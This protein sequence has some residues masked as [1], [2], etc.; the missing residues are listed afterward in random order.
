MTVF[1]NFEFLFQNNGTIFQKKFWLKSFLM[2]S[3]LA[4]LM[5]SWIWESYKYSTIQYC[6]HTCGLYNMMAWYISSFRQRK[7]LLSGNS[8]IVCGWLKN[9]VNTILEFQTAW[10]F[11]LVFLTAS[12]AQGPRSHFVGVGL[13]TFLIFLYIFFALL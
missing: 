12:F 2:V 3:T 8:F 11:G 7:G 5:G 6:K 10:Y 9:R 13:K 1:W 4:G